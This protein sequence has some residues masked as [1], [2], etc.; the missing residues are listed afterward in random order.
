MF[1]GLLRSMGCKI[2]PYEVNP[3]DT[4][5]VMAKAL[6]IIN[7]AFATGGSKEQALAQAI[8]L[9]EQIET[10]DIGTRPKVAI[11]GDLYVRDND[12]MNQDLIHYIEAHGGEVIT[13]P[14]YKYVKIIAGSISE[15]GSRK[16]NIS[17]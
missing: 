3:G 13:T 8:P 2:R 9:F 10:R 15:N 4:D 17:A 12:V 1:G 7:Q 5:Q 6:A 16:V 14:Y 11:F